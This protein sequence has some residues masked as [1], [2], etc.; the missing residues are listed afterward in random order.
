[1]LKQI[2]I[3]FEDF[4]FKD[5]NFIAGSIQLMSSH[6]QKKISQEQIE[7]SSEIKF[8]DVQELNK[9][10]KRICDSWDLVWDDFIKV[11]LDFINKQI[12]IIKKNDLPKEWI[13]IFEE[14]EN[15][16]FLTCFISQYNLPQNLFENNL[17]LSKETFSFAT[18]PLS[19][20]KNE[21]K[22]QLIDI[23][24]K[25]DALVS[26]AILL[27]N[28]ND[29]INCIGETGIK[30]LSSSNELPKILLKQNKVFQ[31]EEPFNLESWVYI[32]FGNENN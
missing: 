20:N 13:N 29:L 21:L 19:D 4:L 6:F 11:F 7:E 23:T 25:S 8:G 10:L 31:I 15:R 22:N 12:S 17:Q 26:E 18:M 1:M 5:T 9:F 16:Q 14:I 24:K 27:T 28:R 30:V 3:G 32:F 2:I